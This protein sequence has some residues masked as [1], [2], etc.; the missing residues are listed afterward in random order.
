MDGTRVTHCHPIAK[1]TKHL[2]MNDHA[3]QYQQLI[4]K[5]W[6]D[7]AFKQRLLADPVETLKAEGIEV[8]EG[9]LVQVVENTAKVMT[10]VIPARSKDLSDDALCE[11]SGGAGF[12]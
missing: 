3:K 9:V 1:G 7:E 10:L 2:T 8:P 5:C 6:D 4:A 11:A 12:T